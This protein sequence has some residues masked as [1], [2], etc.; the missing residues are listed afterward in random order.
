MFGIHPVTHSF[1]NGRATSSFTLVFKWS[2]TFGYKLVFK[3][4][5]HIRLHT[6]F[7]IQMLGKTPV[8]HWGCTLVFK[9]SSY[10]RLHSRLQTVWT[11][12]YMLVFNCPG[13]TRLHTLFQ[14]VGT[15]DYSLVFK[16][17]GHIRLHNRCQTVGLHTRFQIVVTHPVTHSFSNG[18]DTPSY[19]LV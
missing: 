6:R 1:S 19:T 15:P 12:G 3:W 17:S 13:N 14:I 5:G 18:W 7:Q 9:R 8:T 4:S 11:L 2:D 10:T 16:W